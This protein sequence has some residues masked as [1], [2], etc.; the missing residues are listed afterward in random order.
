MRAVTIGG[1]R[2][3]RGIHAYHRKRK[4]QMNVNER[5]ESEDRRRGNI[6]NGNLPFFTKDGLVFHERRTQSDRRG[7]ARQQDNQTD[8]QLA[9]N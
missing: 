4:P 9:L 3:L 6:F 7:P 2:L 5:R 8:E 1:A